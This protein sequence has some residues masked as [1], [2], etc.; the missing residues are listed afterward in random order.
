M[1]AETYTASDIKVLEGLEAVRKRPAIHRDTTAYRLHHLVPGRR[2]L[3]RRGAAGY[4]DSKVILHTDGSCSGGD[5]GRNSRRH[6]Q[7]SGKAAAEVVDGPARGRK[8]RAL[9]VQGVGRPARRGR[10]GG[11]RAKRWLEWRSAATG[12]C[13]RSA[14]RAAPADATAGE[15]TPKHG[16]I[17]SFS[18]RDHSETTFS[19]DALNR[20]RG[21][22]S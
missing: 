6:P 7:E 14:R 10:V 1:S 20:L 2:Q 15:K 21:W 17:V 16:T 19:F 8:V 13:G 4:C 3:R 12:G 5:N 9:G 11:Q 22:P 18:G